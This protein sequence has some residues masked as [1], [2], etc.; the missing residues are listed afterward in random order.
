MAS[1]VNLGPIETVTIN[2]TV[3]GPRTDVSIGSSPCTLKNNCATRVLVHVSA[4]T[5]TTIESDM[6]GISGF[7]VSG[8][9]G[10]QFLL[11]PNG[12][13]KITYVLAP[14]CWFFPI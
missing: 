13:L 1:S 5:V 4:R 6:N 3:T 8:L 7:D 2:S 12:K 9:L 11:N 10:G 14:T